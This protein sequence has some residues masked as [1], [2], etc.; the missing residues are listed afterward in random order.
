MKKLEDISYNK[1]ILVDDSLYYKDS[2]QRLYLQKSFLKTNKKTS[3][4]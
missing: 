3:F 4:F 2:K 1:D